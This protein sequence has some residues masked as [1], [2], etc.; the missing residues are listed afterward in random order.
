MKFHTGVCEKDQVRDESGVAGW[1][2]VGL[3][4]SLHMDQRSIALQCGVDE[5]M[6]SKVFN[7]KQKFVSLLV[8][9]RM[10]VSLGITERLGELTIIPGHTRSDAIQMAVY[11]NLDENDELHVSLDVIEARADELQD[12][13]EAVLAA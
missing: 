2:F 1:E 8:A 9:D 6:L 13:R 10:L 4:Q 12:L 3:L 7:G 11:E 5:G